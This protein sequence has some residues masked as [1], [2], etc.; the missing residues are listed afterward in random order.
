MTLILWAIPNIIQAHNNAIQE[1]HE[2]C[3]AHIRITRQCYNKNIL[4]KL[5]DLKYIGHHPNIIIYNKD[6]RRHPTEKNYF[7]LILDK[8]LHVTYI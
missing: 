2:N 6:L 8:H 7:G 3:I 4:N 1:L 5:L